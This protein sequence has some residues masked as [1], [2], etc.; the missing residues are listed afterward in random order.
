MNKSNFDFSRFFQICQINAKKK[1]N[2]LII[3]KKRILIWKNN[4]IIQ[5]ILKNV[6]KHKHDLIYNRLLV[7]HFF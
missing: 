7:A 2:N 6:N 3:L 4:D 5:Y 1:I